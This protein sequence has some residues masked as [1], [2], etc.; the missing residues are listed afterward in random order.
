MAKKHHPD[1]NPGNIVAEKNFKDV[2]EAYDTLGDTVKRKQYDTSRINPFNDRF[3]TRRS[4]SKQSRN[5]GF[6]DW[7]N[8]Y[9]N[10]DFGD[11]RKK[12]SPDTSHLDINSNYKVNLIDCLNGEP[13]IITY[14]RSVASL[15]GGG[16]TIENKTINVYLKL[17]DKYANIQTNNNNIYSVK[18]KLSNLGNETIHNR[19]N[20]WGEPEME[21]LM[22]DHIID[23]IINVPEDITIEGDNIIQRVDIPLYKVLINGEK[24]EIKTI[25]DKKYNAEVNS[26]DILNELKFSI[27][28]QGLK[29]KSG[30]NGNYVIKFDIKSPNLSNVP[31][32]DLDTLKM[33][34]SQ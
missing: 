2:A 11:R 32:E 30:S 21:M 24:I 13:L 16:A 8:N 31:E 14:N 22:G 4:H 10:N 17:M 12:S 34:L 15:D 7:V 19:V 26:P 25:L 23:V 20:M 27:A 9:S 28:G 29:T 5:T 3:Q 18:I 1:V 33:I 6:D